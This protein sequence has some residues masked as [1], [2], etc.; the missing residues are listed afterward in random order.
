MT[1]NAAE[2]ID[3]V[4]ALEKEALAALT[5][6][7]IADAADHFFYVQGSYPYFVN[8]LG[9]IIV[10]DDSEEF[11]T[12]AYE[13]IMR[14]VMG[15]TTEGS[16]GYDGEPDARLQAYIPQII[17]YFNQRELLQ[18]AAYPAALDD[19]VRARVSGCRGFTVFQQS[20]VGSGII[21]TEFTLSVF[22]EEEI[23][24]TYL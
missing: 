20:G 9:A 16:Q 2:L 18:S 1:I 10:D 3:R 11:D 14:L 4:V 6:T 8:R 21:G 24:Q 19:L 7:V 22:F 17:T 15:H 23:T 12:Y 5:P 13:V